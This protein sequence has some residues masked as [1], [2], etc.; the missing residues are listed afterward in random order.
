MESVL[1]VA[2]PADAPINSFKDIVD[3]KYPIKVSVGA[4]GSGIESLFRK[5]LAY[6]GASYNDIAA[7]G[8]KVEYLN[9][10]DASTLFTDGQLNAVSVLAGMPYSTISEIAASKDIKLLTLEQEAVDA[11]SSQGYLAKT[12]PAGTYTGQ[13]SDVSTVGV[14]ITVCASADANE[15]VV[16]EI[17][18][19]LNSE[20]GISILGNVNS[21]FANYMTGPESGIAGIELELHPGAA[22][23]Y[24]EAGV[25]EYEYMAAVNERTCDT[26]GALDGRRFK[27]D[28]AEPGVNYPPIH[29]N[30][31]CTTV[32]YD[33]EEALDWLNSGEPM[34][35]RTPYQEWYSRQTAA[36]GQGSVE[37]ERKKAYNIKADQEQFDAFLGVLPDGEAPPTLDAFQNVKYTNPEKWRQMKAKVRLYNSTASR[38]TLPEAASAS[39]PQDKLQGYL[40]NHEHPRG[41]E[42][43]HVINQVLGYNVENWETFQKKLLTEVQKS[44]VTKTV[45]TQFGER[46]T[47][48]VILYGRKD[49]FLRLNTVWQIDT[50]G[51]TPHFITATPERKK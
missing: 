39:A 30:C 41:K 24:K 16:Y 45:P 14:V 48:P 50:G 9:I 2:V 5:V 6:Y 20:E 19:F 46:Y 43:A 44:P 33:P 35:K 12:I 34:P 7:W 51:K 49:R 27:V 40:L 13:D 38:G 18:K 28:D 17:T 31:R 1:H 22:R 25:A 37:V 15:A 10:G 29:P 32:E 21:G 11:L 3:Q 23:Y 8:G 26:C 42:K 36:N 4:Q 47:V